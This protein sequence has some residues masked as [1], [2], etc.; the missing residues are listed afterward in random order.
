MLHIAHTLCSSTPPYP[1]Q[2]T[3]FIL[4]Y[5]N[6]RRNTL[7]RRNYI[8]SNLQDSQVEVCFCALRIPPVDLVKV[9]Y[10]DGI[11]IDFKN[12][13]FHTEESFTTV[14]KQWIYRIVKQMFRTTGV[15]FSDITLAIFG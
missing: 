9:H 15:L 6:H 2:L 3:T 4:V 12:K 8:A 11:K 7:A 5:P 13:V 1:S 10:L 14:K